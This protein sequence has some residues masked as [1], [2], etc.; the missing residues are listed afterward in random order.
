MDL[1]KVNESVEKPENV[2]E[3][4][5]TA[6]KSITLLRNE[7]KIFPVSKESAAKT[8]FVVIAADDDAQEGATLVPEI[9]KRYQNAKFARL[10]PRSTRRGIRESFS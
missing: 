1:A 5:R 10:D 3:A 7:G 9:Q 6:E 4:N 2:A 8:L